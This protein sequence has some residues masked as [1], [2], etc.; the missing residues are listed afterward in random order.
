MK[1]IN[2]SKTYEDSLPKYN[3][4]KPLTNSLFSAVFLLL[5]ACCVIPVIF[6]TIIS[7]SSVKSINSIGYSFIP[8]AW[9]LDAY[10][11]LWNNIEMIGRAMGI[12]VFVTI[13]GTLLGLLLTTTMGYVLSKSEYKLKKFLTWVVFIP[14]VFGGGLVSTYNV[15][16]TVLHLGDSVWVLIL[17]MA[18]SSF[19]V[20]ICKTFF[21]TTIPQSIIES[22]EMDGAS[23][24]LIY[25]RIVLPVSKPLLATIGLLLSFAYWNDWWLSL[26]YISN[27]NLYS[28]QAVLMSV[29]RNIEYLS[30]NAN[31]LGA[32]AAEYA[33]KMP[34]ES[35]RMAMAV[36]IVLPIACAYPFFQQYFVSG[37]TIGS[38]KE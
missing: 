7:F 25:S 37:L 6:I 32:S 8:K 10:I 26:M 29:E 28:L 11:Y 14:M 19:Q 1:N 31:T 2:D 18:V 34:K 12:S 27:R 23:Q 20:I 9:S 38:V 21:K 36:I 35:M 17:P 30:Q 15:Y 33:S 16:T 4:I 3:R 24:F 22:A 5:A 13:T